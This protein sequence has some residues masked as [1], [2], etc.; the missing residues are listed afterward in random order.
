MVE[1]PGNRKK[2]DLNE[3]SLSPESVQHALDRI[4]SELQ[5]SFP[6]FEDRLEKGEALFI[7][8][9]GIPVDLRSQRETRRLPK[10]RK[11]DRKADR[12]YAHE[13]KSMREFLASRLTIGDPKQQLPSADLLLIRKEVAEICPFAWT[14]DSIDDLQRALKAAFT[15][16]D[17]GHEFMFGQHFV[18]WLMGHRL[19]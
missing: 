11:R 17:H 7:V 4:F 6:R 13:L 18:W 12:Q 10:H 19:K 15:N 2:L 1:L 9:P 14:V 5:R 8:T 3:M 16:G